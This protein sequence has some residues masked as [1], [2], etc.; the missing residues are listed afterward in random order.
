MTK[1][2]AVRLWEACAGE[3]WDATINA[4]VS[5]PNAKN[6]GKV[7]ASGDSVS[8]SDAAAWDDSDLPP[9]VSGGLEFSIDMP[10]RMIVEGAENEMHRA[11][12]EKLTLRETE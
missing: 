2:A 4:P 8:A 11:G 6:H 1:P 3:P 9:S 12:S 10:H 5:A 7:S